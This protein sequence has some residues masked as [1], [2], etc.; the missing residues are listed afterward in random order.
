VSQW[1]QQDYFW[2]AVALPSLIASWA[3]ISAW[4]AA[5]VELRLWAYSVLLT[6]LVAIPPIQSYLHFLGQNPANIYAVPI[7]LLA[8]LVC[9]C[10]ESPSARIA[11]AGTFVSL[12]IAD[13]AG[14][15]HLSRRLP[16]P[17]EPFPMAIG[18]AGLMDG[19]VLIPIGAGL[20]VVTIQQI[21]RRGHEL[22]FLLGR[23]KYRAQRAGTP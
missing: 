17:T 8:Y 13:L 3:V 1:I 21:L 10:Y 20:L 2:W 11:Y 9:G 6:T 7:F 18:G 12:L 16:S 14:A 4:P 19:L 15:W 5:R 22:S 23:K